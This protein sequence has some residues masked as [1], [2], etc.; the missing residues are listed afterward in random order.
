MCIEIVYQKGGCVTWYSYRSLTALRHIKPQAY[1]TQIS[2]SDSDQQP[3]VAREFQQ[4]LLNAVS[5][6]Q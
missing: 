4:T 5:L 6:Y 1:R 2:Q 3:A